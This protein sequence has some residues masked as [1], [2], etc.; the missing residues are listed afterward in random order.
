M[1]I[2]RDNSKATTKFLSVLKSNGLKDICL[3]FGLCHT[4]RKDELQN[5]I[6]E[7]LRRQST[8]IE[9]LISIDIGLKNL[10]T[11][12]LIPAQPNTLRLQSLEKISLNVDNTSDPRIMAGRVKDFC[13][14]LYSKL[15]VQTKKDVFLIE[16]QTFRGGGN[17]MIPGIVQKLKL[18]EAQLHCFL[19]PHDTQGVDPRKVSC[20]LNFPEGKAK[21]KYAVSLMESWFRDRQLDVGNYLVSLDLGTA[22]PLLFCNDRKKDDFADALLQGVS[23]WMWH[24]NIKKL[25]Q[26]I[27]HTS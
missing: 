23:Y 10:A 16:K 20:S 5:R 11:A 18:I 7:C 27:E 15:G 1:L 4:G 13:D 3:K 24:Q 9:R 19:L 17:L 8:E 22:S 21:K 26:Q 25:K 2:A 6:L 14:S 12:I